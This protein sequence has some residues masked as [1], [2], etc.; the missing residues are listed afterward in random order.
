DGVEATLT[1]ENG[2]VWRWVFTTPGEIPA[3][4]VAPTPET[5]AAAPQPE[6]APQAA[7]GVQ[8]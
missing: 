7:S 5:E 4:T 8:P 6:Q 2:D 3:V 1:M